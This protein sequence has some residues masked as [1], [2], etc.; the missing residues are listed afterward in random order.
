M[1]F[2]SVCSN[3]ITVWQSERD[4]RCYLPFT[5][6]LAS[7]VIHFLF[8]ALS[9]VITVSLTSL[10]G[11]KKCSLLS[12]LHFDSFIK[13]VSKASLFPKPITP[14]QTVSLYRSSCLQAFGIAVLS[15]V[16]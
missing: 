3:V 1:L 15:L 2:P 4:V 8:S 6:L 10:S 7:C 14:L 5:P 12:S 13:G 11:C 9:N 16:M